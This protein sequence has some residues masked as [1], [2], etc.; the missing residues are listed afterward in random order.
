MVAA[1]RAGP[2]EAA[3]RKFV[4]G[5]GALS[6]RQEVLAATAIRDARLLDDEEAGSAATA[7]SRELRQ[8]VTSLEPGQARVPLPAPSTQQARQDS[9]QAVQDELEARRR[10]QRRPA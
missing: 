2:V 9:V 7:L 10:Q 5:L 8:V 4:R 1:R 3:T 6:A